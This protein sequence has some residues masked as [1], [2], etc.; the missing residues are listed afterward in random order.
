MSQCGFLFLSAGNCGLV[1]PGPVV[2]CGVP[3]TES[4]HNLEETT[5]I[6]RS[7]D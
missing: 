7:S 4:Q 6:P 5:G 3:P 2:C 1:P